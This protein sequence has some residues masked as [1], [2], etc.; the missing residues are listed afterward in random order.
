MRPP[1][2]PLIVLVRTFGLLPLCARRRHILDAPYVETLSGPAGTPRGGVEHS[3][4]DQGILTLRRS[5]VSEEP[6]GEDY[7]RPCDQ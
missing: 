3:V 4:I 5:G 1:E 7:A 2:G 6:T